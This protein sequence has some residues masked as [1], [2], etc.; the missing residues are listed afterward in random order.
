MPLVITIFTFGTIS[1][2]MNECCFKCIFVRF[3]HEFRKSFNEVLTYSTLPET[4][5]LLISSQCIKASNQRL[6]VLFGFP[7]PNP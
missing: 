4:R 1:V 6:L 3:P 5:N 7:K 2:K